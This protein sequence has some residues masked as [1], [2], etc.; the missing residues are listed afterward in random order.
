MLGVDAVAIEFA[1]S[2]R[3]DD[4]AGASDNGKPER[5]VG[6]AIR[7]AERE[8]ARDALRLVAGRQ[9][10]RADTAVQDRNAETY[11]FLGQHLD[12]QSA[13]CAARNSSRARLRHDPS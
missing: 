5:V 3:R 12:H 9:N 13:T 4:E 10:L 2:A 8:Q 1:G 6:S 7:G 11:R